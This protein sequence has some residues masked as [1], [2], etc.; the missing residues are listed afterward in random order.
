MATT[1]T[2]SSGTITPDLITGYDITR[3]SRNVLHNIV[4]RADPDVTLNAAGL[5]SGTLS[6][7]FGSKA[8]AFECSNAHGLATTFT[9]TDDDVPEMNMKYVVSGN[10][11]L[12]LDDS[13]AAWTVTLDVVEVL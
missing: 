9:I 12:H 8:A 11:S 6:L 4:N 2:Y 1:I 3:A 5:R 7:I 10:I 13:R